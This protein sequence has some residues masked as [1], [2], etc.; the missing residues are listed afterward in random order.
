MQSDQITQD[1]TAE[2]NSSS[3]TSPVSEDPAED[4]VQNLRREVEVRQKQS[5]F[6]RKVLQ[7]F[8]GKCCITGISEQCLLVASHIKP[9]ADHVECRLDV[10][11]GLLLSVTYDK[12]FDR[13]LI[14][15]ADDLSVIV[16]DWVDELSAPLR[17]LLHEISGRIASKPATNPRQDYL[18]FHR[19]RIFK[20]RQQRDALE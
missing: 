3:R 8:S 10:R 20:K 11:N 15:F 14:T 5:L 9:W 13:G 4:A 17:N 7:N 1:A 12:L 16:V 2:V 19:A 6:R 18:A